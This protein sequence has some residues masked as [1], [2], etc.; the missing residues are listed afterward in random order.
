[1]ILVD[2]SVWVDHLR[3]GEPRLE[4]LLDQG[5]VLTH[6][7]V[8]GEIALGT[9]RRRQEVL[10]LLSALPQAPVAEP[11]EILVLVEGERLMGRGIGYVDV[12]L[13]AAAKLASSR[14]WTRDR[15]LAA[16]AEALGFAFQENAVEP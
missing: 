8:V 4:R 10:G 5:L 15:R 7:W 6:P 9:L 11:T 2:S 1:V 16:A 3:R 12:Q 14:L 13:L